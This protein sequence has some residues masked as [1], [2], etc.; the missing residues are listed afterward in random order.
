MRAAVDVAATLN[1]EGIS[2]DTLTTIDPVSW[3]WSRSAVGENVGQW[4]NVS[5]APSISNG[6]AG[7][8]WAR[9]GGKWNNGYPAPFHHNEFGS[10]MDWTRPGGQSPK[11]TLLNSNSGCVCQ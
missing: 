2:V 11:S 8:T 1:S 9:I 7:D 3:S 6:F 10:M 4:V 5:A